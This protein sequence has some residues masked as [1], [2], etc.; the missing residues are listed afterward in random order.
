MKYEDY[1]A[2]YN[3]KK[4]NYKNLVFTG[5]MHGESTRSKGTPIF[6]YIWKKDKYWSIK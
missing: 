5:R 1:E 6:R 3:E 2:K 4:G